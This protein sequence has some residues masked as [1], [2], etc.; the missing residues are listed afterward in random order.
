MERKQIVVAA[1]LS[2][3]IGMPMYAAAKEPKSITLT[4]IGRYSAGA[5]T[6]ADEPRTE[7]VAFDPATTRLFSV[8]LN[9][10]QLDV[11]D[12]SNPATPVLAQSVPLGGKP[13]SVAAHDGIVAVAVEGAQKTDA[14]N[15]QFFN[16]S[17]ALLNKLTVGALPDMVTFS[18]N[19]RWLLVAN[20]G[21]PSSY[22]NNPVPSVDPEGSVS[23]I[24]MKHD[25]TSLTQLDVRTATFSQTIPQVNPS[26]I[27]VYGPNATFAQ[28][29][30][31]EYITVSHDSKTAWVVLQ[32]NNAIAILHITSATFTKLVGLGFKDHKLAANKLDASDRD[33][34]GSSNNG[35]INIRNWPVSGIYEPDSIANY[36]VKGDT[37]LVMANEGDTRDYPPGFTEEVRVGALSLDASSFASQGYPDV[38]TTTGLR[39]NDNLGRLTVTNTLGNT[40]ADTD[41]EQLYVPGGR[42]FSIRRADGSLVFDSGDEFE[43]RTAE[44]V[45]TL[46]NSQGDAA[47]FDT[48][49]DNK[50][51]EPEAL[52]L[53]KVSG[54]MYAFIGFERTGGVI[55]YDISNPKAPIFTTYVTTAPTDLAPEGMIFI[56]KKDSPTHRPL[57]VVSH[58]VSNT[59]T[60]F[61]I[62]KDDG[63]DDND[64]D[65]ED[66]ED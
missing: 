60:I 59:I 2:C 48:R 66:N 61:E 53:G 7:I 39:N 24:D 63:D 18:P 40:D 9:L 46:F 26:S 34:P 32:E 1:C 36:R 33:V 65:D 11:L 27:R 22:N 64:E 51:P 21:E 41:F 16:T 45:P 58:E 43:Q 3:L 14:G 8:N 19:G 12:L 38:S 44:L 4:E 15:V 20:E 13:N 29:M 56:K 55:V 5:S 6:V 47:S 62:Q 31:P 28:D 30:E 42:S 35:I 25:V 23:I 57:L 49:S 17:G 10:R 52:A 54:R 37:Y 50:G